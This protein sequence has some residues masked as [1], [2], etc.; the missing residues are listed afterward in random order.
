[1]RLVRGNKK[2]YEVSNTVVCEQINFEVDEVID[3]SKQAKGQATKG[4]W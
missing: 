1:M 3:H 4:A 2:I